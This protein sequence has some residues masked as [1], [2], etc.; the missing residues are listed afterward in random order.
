MKSINKL[1]IP[2]LLLVVVAGCKKSFLERPSLSQVASNNFYQT[3]T[4]IRLATASLYGGPTVWQ[5]HGNG[6]LQFGDVLSGN[7]TTGQYQGTDNNEL[8]AV[9]LSASNGYVRM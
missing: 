9:N 6:V 7:G 2:L 8:F 3:T 1:F 4:E 5:W